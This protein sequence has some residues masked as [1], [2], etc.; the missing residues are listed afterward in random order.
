MARRSGSA[1]RPVA[2]SILRGAGLLI[3]GVL[4]AAALIVAMVGA[5]P[6]APALV[7]WGVIVLVGVAFKRWRYKPAVPV[8]GPGFEPTAERFIDPCSGRPVQVFADPKT[9][10]RRYVQR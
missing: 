7:F 4:L 2:R 10:E 1:R 8:A 5:A 9:G 3:G 6:A